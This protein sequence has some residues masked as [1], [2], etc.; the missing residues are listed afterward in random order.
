MSRP[1]L[2]ICTRCSAQRAEQKD[3]AACDGQGLLE[4]VKAL[5]KQRDLKK[6]FK[7]EEVRCLKECR[8]PCVVELV[9]IKRSTYLRI[10]IHARHDAEAVVNAAVL[11]AQLAPGRE[12]P[13]S[14]LPGDDAG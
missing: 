7:V 1:L 14:A 4:Q 10:A 5:R 8:T 12:L 6:V 2:R 11:Y 13:E 3:K 9:G